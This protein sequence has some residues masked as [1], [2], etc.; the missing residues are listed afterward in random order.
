M[1]DKEAYKVLDNVIKA[2]S[3]EN[4][5]ISD[6]NKICLKELYLKLKNNIDDADKLKLMHR[7][8]WKNGLN[9][10]L[11]DI[12]VKEFDFN[13]CDIILYDIT[14]YRY[15]PGFKIRLEYYKENIQ[16]IK[17]KIQ[18]DEVLIE[19]INSVL[20]ADFID[21]L[22]LNGANKNILNRNLKLNTTFIRN[23]HGFFR[24]KS[25]KSCTKD[26]VLIK[27]LLDE[28]KH[29]EKKVP[30]VIHVTGS[31]GKGSTCTFLKYILEAN[32]YKINM[33]TNPFVIRYSEDYIVDGEEITDEMYNELIYKVKEAYDKVILREDYKKAVDK[34]NEFDEGHEKFIINNPDYDGVLIWSFSVVV[35][36]L[37]FSRSKADF[38]IIEVRNGGMN[39]VTNVFTENETVATVLTHIE[40]GI[41]S[42]DGTMPIFIN[43]VR[44]YSNR[45]TAYHKSKLGKKNV[46]MIIADQIEEVLNE[47]RRVAK[48]E[49]ETY[50]VEYGREWFIER[51]NDSSF[52]F[53]GFDNKLEIKKSKT[54]FESFQTKNIATALAVIFKLQEQGKIKTSNK[55][56]QKG[57]DNTKIA[58]RL[59]KILDGNLVNY[60]NNKNLEIITGFIKLNKIGVNDFINIINCDDKYNYIIYTSNNLKIMKDN[61][62][63]FEELNKVNKDKFELLL[64]KKN[65]DI[66]YYILE[67]IS[68]YNIDF[69]IKEN[70]SSALVYV[71]NKIDNNN[72]KNCRVLIVCDS[73]IRFDSNIE[74]LNS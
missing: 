52:V 72:I 18:L 13:L 15:N 51:E 31:N 24:S 39:D 45:A 69:K 17:N 25:S 8:L 34:A 19:S 7:S 38:S 74:Y 56:I 4:K 22:V 47:I 2:F 33:Y 14:H 60:F 49:V 70:L 68:N 9:K 67:Q 62:V 59:Q 46:P 58:G 1:V 42:N 27:F 43:G 73:M 66:F 36:I 71:K 23:N 5:N 53:K 26:R 55:L 61:I 6:K 32:G 57:I 10:E 21:L 28:L 37:A 30:N 11:M 3:L 41:G 40:Y 16:Y 54:L 44:E 20:D 50:T 12:L 64:Y 35:M 48:E 65:N 63:F 29:P